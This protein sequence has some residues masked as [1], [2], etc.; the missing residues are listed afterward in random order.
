[1]V[2]DHSRLA[3]VELHRRD[4]EETNIVCL[5][6]ALAFF[7]E[8]GLS[9]P[10]AVMTDGAMVYAITVHKGQGSQLRHVFFVVPQEDANYFGREL[11]YTGLTRAQDTLTLFVQ[12]DI[13]P[14]LLC[15]SGRQQERRSVT[16]VYFPPRSLHFPIVP[17]CSAPPVATESR[18]S[19]R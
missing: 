12:R 14:F 6:R 7:A 5:E 18:A 2:D 9:P 8:H 15:G 1:M 16:L 11:T 13:G 4:T 3:Y 19:P 17:A 10:E